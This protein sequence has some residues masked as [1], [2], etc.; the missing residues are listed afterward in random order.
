MPP[1]GPMEWPGLS[2]PSIYTPEGRI[3]QMAA[4]SSNL[5]KA[6][7]ARG[8]TARFLWLIGFPPAALAVLVRDVARVVRKRRRA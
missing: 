2:G 1:T 5:A 8:I 6:T 4:I 7:G 3:R